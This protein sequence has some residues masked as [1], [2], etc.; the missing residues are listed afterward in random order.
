MRHFTRLIQPILV[1]AFVLGSILN[2]NAADWTVSKRFGQT[3]VEMNGVQQVSLRR[4]SRVNGD[5]M[6]HTGVDGKIVLVRGRELITVGPNSSISLKAAMARGRTLIRQDS[7]SVIYQVQTRNKPHFTVQ[8]G[9]IAAL[10]KGTK[11]KVVEN[12]HLS[13]VWVSEGVVQV[14]VFSTGETADIKSGQAAIFKKGRNGRL[15]II[16]PGVRDAV[17]RTAGAPNGI[18][19][20]FTETSSLNGAL[21]GA[22]SAASH[23]ASSTSAAASGAVSS[24]AGAASGA[25][26]SAAGAASSVGGALDDLL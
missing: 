14:F 24:A 5:A 20:P 12:R 10:V 17:T 25:A 26:S 13:K 11:F 15:I 8:T 3:R 21:S 18:P 23:A 16:G 19:E 6:V 22:T 2:A 4:G 9:T 7:G 1:V